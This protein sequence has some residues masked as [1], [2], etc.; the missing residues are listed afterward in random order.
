MKL[1]N[2]DFVGGIKAVNFILDHRIL[3]PEREL[4]DWLKTG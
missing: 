2:V 1:K 4:L 3:L